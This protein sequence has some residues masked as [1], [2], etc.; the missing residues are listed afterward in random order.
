MRQYT[1]GNNLV[2]FG[3]IIGDFIIMNL[4]LLGFVKW[5]GKDLVPEYILVSK[6]I[7]FVVA[8]MA[9]MISEYFF[10]ATVHDRKIE[11]M[12]VMTRA[13]WLTFTHVGL[14]FIT[15]RILQQNGGNFSR[16]MLYFGAVE[17]V[18]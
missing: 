14:L 3:V 11:I 4:L 7:T 8:N 17:Y 13:F 1:N 18:V 16:F 12:R 2:K 15:L 9:M 10:Y 5:G 6:R